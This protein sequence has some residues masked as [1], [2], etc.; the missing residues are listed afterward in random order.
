MSHRNI[1]E[2]QYLYSTAIPLFPYGLYGNYRTS[3]PVWYSHK[4]NPPKDRTTS[5]EPQGP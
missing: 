4:S 5:T 3:V 2:A 1:T